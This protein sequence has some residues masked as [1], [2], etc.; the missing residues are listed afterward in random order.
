MIFIN[1]W[2]K[3]QLFHVL[4][5]LIFQSF[6]GTLCARSNFSVVQ[7]NFRESKQI[8]TWFRNMVCI[9]MNLWSKRLL[10]KAGQWIKHI[11]NLIFNQYS[12]YDI[13]SFHSYVDSDPGCEENV[14]L[15]DLPVSG[16]Y[17]TLDSLSRIW[18]HFIYE[19]HCTLCL[20]LLTFN[21]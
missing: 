17:A 5:W 2:N 7:N 15:P 3:Q 6:R 11:Y 16:L 10:N 8:F 1:S 9:S 19:A 4:M 18:L 13:K 20:Y 21:F 12:L 14:F